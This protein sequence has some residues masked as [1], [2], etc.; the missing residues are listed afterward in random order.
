MKISRDP[1]FLEVLSDSVYGMNEVGSFA[2]DVAI[3][4]KEKLRQEMTV[5]YPKYYLSAETIEKLR[6]PSFNIWPWTPDEVF[7]FSK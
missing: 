2:S 6:T 1:Y 3:D 7:C 4:K 5:L